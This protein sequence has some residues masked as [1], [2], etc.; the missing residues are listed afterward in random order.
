[1][2]YFHSILLVLLGFSLGIFPIL[3][4]AGVFKMRRQ[5]TIPYKSP[6]FP[7]VQLVFILAGVSILLLSF[8]ER[9]QESSIAIGTVAIGIPVYWIFK[10]R[11]QE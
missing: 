3:T 11:K 1:M 4:V 7:I 2:R 10:K 5:N 6:G 9:P 8:F